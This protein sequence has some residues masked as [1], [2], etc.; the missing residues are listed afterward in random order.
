MTK[1][2]ARK[3]ISGCRTGFSTQRLLWIASFFLLFIPFP[4]NASSQFLK[5][6]QLLGNFE[7]TYAQVDG[8]AQIPRG[9]D[10]KTTARHRPNFRELGLR[11]NDYENYAIGLSKNDYRVWYHFIPIHF[12]KATILKTALLTQA[13]TIPAGHFFNLD[14]KLN[15][16]QVLIEKLFYSLDH[17][18]VFIPRIEMDYIKYNYFFSLE[19]GGGSSRGFGNSVFRLGMKMAVNMRHRFS[20]ELDGCASM[21]AHLNIISSDLRLK[22]QNEMG[23]HLIY[24]PYFG[25]GYLRIDTNDRQGVSNHIRYVNNPS[26]FLGVEVQLI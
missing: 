4:S 5:N 6:W 26:L 3:L 13:Q 10:S 12:Q 24:T 23:N 19:D 9:G 2:Q 21:P 7:Y 16:H 18:L 25:I 20:L 17:T 8:F 14:L 15:M 22:W 11:Y 1:T